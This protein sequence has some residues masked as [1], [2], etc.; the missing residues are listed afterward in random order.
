MEAIVDRI[1]EDIVVIEYK[2]KMYDVNINKA[3]GEI[4]EG[5]VVEITI[6]N[7]EITSVKKNEKATKSR[8]KYIEDLVKDMWQD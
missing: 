2:E 3:K 1:E 4:S 5:D 8:K 6:E 7:D